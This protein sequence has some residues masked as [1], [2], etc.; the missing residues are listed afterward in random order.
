[1]PSRCGKRSKARRVEHDW[2]ETEREKEIY[3]LCQIHENNSKTNISTLMMGGSGRPKKFSESSI[4]LQ[5][6]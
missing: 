6:F 4:E 3:S 1:M 2:S 5:Q